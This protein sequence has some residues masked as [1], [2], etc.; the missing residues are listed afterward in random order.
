[1]RSVRQLTGRTASRKCVRFRPGKQR[2]SD[3]AA[4]QGST[5]SDFMIQGLRLGV[6]GFSKVFDANEVC[7]GLYGVA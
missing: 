1:M 4:F 3:A 5:A 2:R 7:A 6:W